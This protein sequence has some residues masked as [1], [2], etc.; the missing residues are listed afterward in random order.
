[1]T[2]DPPSQIRTCLRRSF[3][4]R[5][6]LAV[7]ESLLGKI[8]VRKLEVQGGTLTL[9][10]YIVET[11]AYGCQDDPAS[12]AFG[13]RTKRNFVMF[14]DVGRLYV[15]FVYG[16]HYCAN[17]T[18]KSNDIEAGAVLIRSILP[19]TGQDVMSKMRKHSKNLTMGPGR[20][21]EALS[22]TLAHNG[23]DVTQESSVVSIHQGLEIS[24]FRTSARIGISRAIERP[25]RFIAFRF[26]CGLKTSVVVK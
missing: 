23:L 7:A 6:T 10:G 26:A 5:D 24:E 1:M 15:Y 8:L 11:E 18:A 16:N 20:L 22:I 2:V 12:H 25:W 21:T 13:G 3:Y 17:V 4:K 9:A 14:G 19:L